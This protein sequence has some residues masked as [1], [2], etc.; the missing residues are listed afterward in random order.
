MSLAIKD[1]DRERVADCRN[2]VGASVGIPK[3]QDNKEQQPKDDL[4]N[5]MDALDAMEL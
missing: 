5:L 2:A 4:D 1:R 3:R